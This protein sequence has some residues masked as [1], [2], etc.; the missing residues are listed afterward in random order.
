[1]KRVHRSRSAVALAA[2]HATLRAMALATLVALPVLVG[3]VYA[4]GGSI[5]LVGPDAQGLSWRHVSRVLHDES[6][7]RGLAWTVYAAAAATGLAMTAAIGIAV[8]YR[9]SRAADRIARVAAFAPFPV[10]YVVAASITVLFLGQSGLLSRLGARAGF[11]HAPGDFPP[12]VFDQP[13]VGFIITFAWKEAAFLA[14]VAWSVLATR[15]ATLEEAAR[16]L[17]AGS[18]ATFWRVTLPVLWRGMAP[19]LVLV[20][21]FIAGSYE[22]AALLGPSDPLPFPVGTYERYN[23]LDLSRRG[24][25]F[26]LTLMGLALTVVAVGLFEWVRTRSEWD[27]S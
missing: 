11:L 6:V 10:P 19:A 25:A 7:W 15:G 20:F 2:G 5:G 24:E 26:V 3:V 1:M 16:T 17:G 21:V 4:A 13:G 22:A 12:L 23:D 27:S 8:G 18:G 14:F 9:R